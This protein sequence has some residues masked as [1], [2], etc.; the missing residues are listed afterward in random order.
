MVVYSSFYNLRREPFSLSPD[1]G[2]IYMAPTH[3]EAMAQL[4][5]TVQAR[6]GLAVLTGE[7]GTGKTT[8]MRNLLESV[9]D[10]VRTAYV[11]NPPRTRTELFAA[12]AS[13][14]ALAP[15]S[16]EAWNLTLHNFLIDAFRNGKTVVAL[17]DEAQEIPREVLEEIRLLTNLETANTKL[18]QVIL[19]GQPEL[20]AI[21]DSNDMRALRQRIA[22]R[23]SLSSLTPDETVQYILKR[24]KR[25]GADR[26]PFELQ[27]CLA[28]HDYAAGIPRVINLLCDQCLLSG[29]VADKRAIDARIVKSVATANKLNASR[30]FADKPSYAGRLIQSSVL[31]SSRALRAVTVAAVL[32]VLF[33]V[34][35]EVYP[36]RVGAFAARISSERTP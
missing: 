19:A 6:K 26:S 29:Y 7:V 20:D 11:L 21:L 33:A 28:I 36:E 17:F 9:G 2:F 10:D 12:L 18:L 4:A 8:L 34:F 27:A 25:A 30:T 31:R 15:A 35:Y 16:P 13:E 22:L 23:Y 32:A 1:P 3:R 14:F 5:Y 24:L